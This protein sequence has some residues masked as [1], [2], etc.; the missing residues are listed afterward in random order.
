MFCQLKAKKI[1]FSCF[2]LTM[3]TPCFFKSARDLAQYIKARL[4]SSRSP[5]DPWPVPPTLLLAPRPR[6]QV[7]KA[8]NLLEEALQHHCQSHVRPACSWLIVSPDQTSWDV[9]EYVAE[10]SPRQSGSNEE[11]EKRLLA[12]FPPIYSK[13][14]ENDIPYVDKPCHIID[15]NGHILLWYLPKVFFSEIARVI[16]FT[17]LP[18]QDFT[19]IARNSFGNKQVY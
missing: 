12:W 6:A 2:F 4:Q 9:R 10:L 5:T 1:L 16:T 18:A 11:L 15:W 14:F 19:V 13:K 7:E 17:G 3:T 8:I